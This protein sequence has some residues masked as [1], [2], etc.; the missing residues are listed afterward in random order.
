MNPDAIAIAAELDQER[1][2]GSIRGYL[3]GIPVLV[4]DV[5]HSLRTLL[6]LIAEEYFYQ[7]Q[8]ADNCGFLGSFGYESTEGRSCGITAT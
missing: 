3:H 6:D 2:N 5:C 4:K 1:R 8:N 7:R